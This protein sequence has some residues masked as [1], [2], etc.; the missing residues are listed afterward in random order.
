MK[1][2]GHKMAEIGEDL[3]KA[4]H[5]DIIDLCSSES[6]LP[7]NVAKKS[8]L[9][10]TLILFLITHFDFKASFSCQDLFIHDW[11]FYIKS[12][13]MLQLCNICWKIFLAKYLK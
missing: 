12:L 1:E 11:Y 9:G 7:E 4:I 10:V 13:F 8:I 2:F 6:I 3:D 5:H